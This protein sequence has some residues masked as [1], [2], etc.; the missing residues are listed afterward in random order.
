M[1]TII[2]QLTSFLK[3]VVIS[4]VPFI[5]AAQG[6]MLGGRA[7][8]FQVAQEGMMLVGASVGF[9]IGYRTGGLFAGMVAAALSGGLFALVLAYLTTALRMNQFVVGLA[10]FFIGTGLSTLLPKL[11][12]GVTMVQP[13]IPTLVDIPI[14]LLSQIPVLGPVLFSQNILVYFSIL[15]TVA[16]WWF[17]YRTRIGLEVRSVGE[18]PMAADSLGVNVKLIRY[19]ATIIGGI[20]IG[21]AGAYLPMVYTGT[22]TEGMTRNRGWISIALTF[23][24]AWSPLPIFF[25]SLFFA[26][27]EVLSFRVQVGGSLIPYQFLQMLPYIA[28]I[29][30]MIFSFRR[31]RVPGFLG[32]NYDREKRSLV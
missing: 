17:L 1:E 13:T 8:V 32:N 11:V 31:S 27:I 30:V 20:L 3:L 16:L 10:L 21:L 29:L 18:N 15:L 12:I 4:M 14:P 28:T 23:F 7:G 25:G 24:G 5:L 26:A 6:T 2:P 22:F 19:A 9:L